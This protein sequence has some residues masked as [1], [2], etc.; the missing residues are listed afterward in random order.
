MTTLRPKRKI[1]FTAAA[2][3]GGLLL[4]FNPASATPLI[5]PMGQ[6]AAQ[7]NIAGSATVTPTAVMFSNTAGTVAN[8]FDASTPDTGSY[9]GLTGGTIDNLSGPPFTGPI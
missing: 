6:T 4:T 5:I 1:I 8:T 7:A 2:I 9:A 3:C